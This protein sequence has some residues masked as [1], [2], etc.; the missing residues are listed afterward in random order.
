MASKLLKLNLLGSSLDIIIS[1]KT[2]NMRV[3]VNEIGNHQ[4]NKST[5]RQNVPSILFE[6]F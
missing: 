4:Q 6:L 1:L 5:L 3:T 2:S